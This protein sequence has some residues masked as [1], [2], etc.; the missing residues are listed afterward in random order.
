[1]VREKETETMKRMVIEKKK[2]T[3][4]EKNDERLVID[5]N[6]VSISLTPGLDILLCIAVKVGTRINQKVTY[7]NVLAA[8][9]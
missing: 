1:M 9:K 2:E 8:H 6:S 7:S 3:N 4:N 5:T